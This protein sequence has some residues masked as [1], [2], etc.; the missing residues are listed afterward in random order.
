MNIDAMSILHED[1]PNNMSQG[2]P[3]RQPYFPTPN[4]YDV[5]LTEMA[6]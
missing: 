1:D 6:S 3:A 4:Q 5:N 2:T